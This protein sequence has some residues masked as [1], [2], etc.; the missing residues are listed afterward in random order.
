MD[1]PSINCGYLPDFA[2]NDL[3]AVRAAFQSAQPVTLG[4][5]WRTQLELDFQ[6]ATVRTGWRDEALLVFAELKDLDIGSRATG[7]NQ[8]M[9]ELGDA[10]EIFLRPVEQMAYV[11]F[12][13][14][15]NNQRLQLR[16][17]DTAAL[18]QAQQAN[19]FRPFLLGGPVIESAA[20]VEP[21]NHQWFA[22]GRIPARAVYDVVRPMRGQKWMFSFSRYDYTTGR[23]QPVLSST[24]P[25]HTA[26]DFHD[27]RDWGVITF[28]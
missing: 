17:P 1:K 27:Q 9:W 23:P 7:L 18:R 21:E 12:H 25:H 11:E 22:F 3:N 26:P 13:V 15:P 19:E 6:P 28:I 10:L 8:R 14:T 2:A 16:F 4:Q 20:W 24:S 5:G